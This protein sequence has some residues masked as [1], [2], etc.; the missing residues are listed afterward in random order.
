MLR[1]LRGW[2][3]HSSVYLVCG[4]MLNQGQRIFIVTNIL[5]L[6]AIPAAWANTASIDQRI[7]DQEQRTNAS[8]PKL[9]DID[10]PATTVTDWLAQIEASLVQITGVRVETTEAG[11]QVVLETAEGELSTPATQTVGDAVIAEIPNAV[12]ALPDGESFEQFEPAE[13]IA[14]VRVTELPSDRVQVSI[15]GTDAPPQAEMSV[16][17]GNL[18]LSVVPGIAQ[19][20]DADEAIEL[21]VTGEQEEDYVVDDATTAT[22]TDTP[23]R[24]IP[25]SIQVIPKQVL[26]DQQV[27]Q[28]REAVRNVSGV[29]EGSNFGNGA[30]AFLIRG[31]Q[32]DNILLDGIELGSSFLGLNSSFRET[33]NIERVEVLKGP[34]SVLYGALEPGGIVNVITEQPLAFSFY[35]VEPQAGSFELFRPSIDLSGPLNSDRTLLYRLNA[36]YQ[37]AD[38]FRDFDQGI[39]R[40]FV[41][42]VLSWAIGNNTD[43]TLNFEYL[44]DE[45]PFDRGLPAIDDEVADIPFDRILG[46]PDDVNIR[47][48]Y[49]NPR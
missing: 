34:A 20:G 38:G 8:I 22:R 12:L 13:G 14:L 47:E 46:E 32:T 6:A 35:E 24:D 17:A 41:A 19:A 15:T 1:E 7:N 39:E 27:I 2:Y 36:I 40:F 45:R 30:D 33:A 49:S 28:L 23:L 16:E 18:V 48:Q 4:V 44:N 26:E 11:L 43:L 3:P 5:S 29:V 10:Q 25:Q 42:P 31:F 21:V 9:S 37:T